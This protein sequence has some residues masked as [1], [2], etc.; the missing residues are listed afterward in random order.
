PRSDTHT[1][2]LHAALPI[3]ALEGFNDEL[4]EESLQVAISA[5]RDERA[6]GP[7]EFSHGN[8]TGG[9]LAAEEMKAALELLVTTG[10]R[11]YAERF[12]D[13]KSTR[14]NSSHVKISY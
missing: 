10:D 4:A 5:W 13:R 14:L 11:E 9:P 6:N 2:S 12:L 8:T 1:L 3:W 7:L